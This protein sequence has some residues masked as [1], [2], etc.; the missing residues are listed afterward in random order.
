MRTHT[1][2]HPSTRST[3][4]RGPTTSRHGELTPRSVW[5]F[6]A[7]TFALS[8]GVGALVVTFLD[9]VEALLGPLGYTNPAFIVL[10]NRRTLLDKGSGATSVL[11][12][13]DGGSPAPVPP[14][15]L[16][17]DRSARM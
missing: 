9:Q 8:W 3:E 2:P 11:V 4:P 6:F 13:T 17:P 12:D 1:R 14:G 7:G 15:R 16:T 5:W 10:V